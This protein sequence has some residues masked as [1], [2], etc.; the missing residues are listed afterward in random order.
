MPARGPP[1]GRR[2]SIRRARPLQRC[3]DGC[4]AG[5]EH[6]GDLGCAEAEHVAEHERRPLAGRQVL[7]RGHECE[8]DRL[9]RLV[10]GLRP[11][12]VSA[13]PRAGRRG[14]APA[15]S[16]RCCG[17]ARAGS[18]RR[19]LRGRRAAVAQR[20]QAA[21]GRDPVEPGAQ[22]GAFLEPA[23]PA[24]GREQRFLHDVLGVL[25]RAEDAVAV[26]LQLCAVR[27]DELAKCGLV[28]RAGAAEGGLGHDTTS[29]RIAKLPV[30]IRRRR[31]RNEHD[32][33]TGLMRRRMTEPMAA[34]AAGLIP[35]M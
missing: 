31:C 8:T 19:H 6:L 14:R 29:L 21:V 27:V 1:A 15:R 28:A 23:Q 26:Q 35:R 9:S 13:S 2:C 17:S 18:H 5:V 12:A 20:V 7:Q 3:F 25:E 11:G 4:L 10:A 16:A 22:R 32:D 33:E 34:P 24:P 30:R